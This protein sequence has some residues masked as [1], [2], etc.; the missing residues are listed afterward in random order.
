MK[1][2]RILIV[3]DESGM[4]EVCRDALR[5]LP[6]TVLELESNSRYAAERLK[7]EQFDLL[8]TD[9]RMPGMSGAELVRLARKCDGTLPV[10]VVTAYALNEFDP[11]A[12]TGGITRF[13]AKPFH[14][15]ALVAAVGRLLTASRC[16]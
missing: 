12:A 13:I 4:L 1:K 8:I 15:D 10:L 16:R 2:A 7:R 6:N 14:P 5:D 9:L 3:D 11:A